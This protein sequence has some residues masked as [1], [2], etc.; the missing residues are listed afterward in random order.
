M[1]AKFIFCFP[2]TELLAPKYPDLKPEDI[3][4]TCGC[5][6]LEIILDSINADMLV[7]LCDI[8]KEKKLAGTLHR[9]PEVKIAYPDSVMKS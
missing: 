6:C 5:K 4:F 1:I 2:K 3:T 8:H 7:K 9:I